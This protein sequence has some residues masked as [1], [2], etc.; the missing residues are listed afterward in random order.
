MLDE[1]SFYRFQ[2]LN[3]LGVIWTSFQILEHWG[4]QFINLWK[5]VLHGKMSPRW[6]KYGCNS[7]EIK[8]FSHQPSMVYFIIRVCKIGSFR[9]FS[10]NCSK[11]SFLIGRFQ[12]TTGT[13]WIRLFSSNSCFK[14]LNV[15]SAEGGHPKLTLFFQVFWSNSYFCKGRKNFCIRGRQ[16]KMDLLKIDFN[17]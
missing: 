2:D 9:V 5:I 17:G 10:L 8:D 7:C 16:L 3:V 12:I 1:L 14:F 6:V 15:C 11:R 13:W 4:Q